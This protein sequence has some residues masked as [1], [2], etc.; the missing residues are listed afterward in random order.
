MKKILGFSADKHIDAIWALTKNQ[1]HKKGNKNNPK[2]RDK[3]ERRV[4]QIRSQLAKKVLG[5]SLGCG[6]GADSSIRSL[7]KSWHSLVYLS[8][9]FL[10]S[11]EE[12]YLYHSL[13]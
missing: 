5:V 11:L 6:C 9:C 10:F 2:R 12:C 8:G 7:I 1:R 13:L 4:N 3:E